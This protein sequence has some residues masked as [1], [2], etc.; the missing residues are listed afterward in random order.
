MNWTYGLRKKRLLQRLAAAIERQPFTILLFHSVGRCPEADFLPRSLDCDPDFFEDVLKLLASKA[1]VLSLE[2]LARAVRTYKLPVCAAAITFDDGF[3]DNFTVA[4]PLLQQ[5]NMPATNFVATDAIGSSELLPVHKYYYVAQKHGFRP[6]VEPPR[7]TPQQR[8]EVDEFCAA[9][10]ITVPAL[11]GEIYLTWEELHSL[12]SQ[13]IEI[14][15]HTCSHPW[16]A[17]FPPEQQEREIVGSKRVLED[18]LGLSVRSFAYPY[19]Y[20]TSFDAACAKLVAATYDLACLSVDEMDTSIDLF[21]TP[22]QNISR[23]LSA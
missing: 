19:G 20:G 18:K 4:G 8:H 5:Y 12:A 23:F 17:A 16:L 6:R 15:A 1:K 9:R 21:K 14:G 7:D 3:R 13:G 10:S 22:R 11:G 2:E